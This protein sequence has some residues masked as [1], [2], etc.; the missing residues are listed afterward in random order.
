M[1]IKAGPKTRAQAMAFDGGAGLEKAMR[2]IKSKRKVF[3]RA[4]R[5]LISKIP[6][7][8]TRAMFDARHRDLFL[9][10][11][12]VQ[13]WS[14]CMAADDHMKWGLTTCAEELLERFNVY[15]RLAVHTR[16]P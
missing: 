7:N 2:E 15:L 4:F 11:K 6:D 10:A 14:S 3:L 8:T 16:R 1:A 13:Y 12:A 5:R 9:Q